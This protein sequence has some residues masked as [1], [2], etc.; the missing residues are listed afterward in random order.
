MKNAIIAPISCVG[1]LGI[2]VSGVIALF[3]FA[4]SAEAE[5]EKIELG[6]ANLPECTRLVSSGESFL[7]IPDT[8]E[9]TPQRLTAYLNFEAPNVNSVLADAQNCAAIAAAA[10]G[11]SA[12][13]ANPAAVQPSFFASFSACMSGKAW[14][15]LSLS[16]ETRCEGW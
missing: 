6:W 1:I 11:L 5:S 4:A 7:N 12:V 14:S 9:H 10:A 8:Y 16:T 15:S 3:S 2:P 13:I